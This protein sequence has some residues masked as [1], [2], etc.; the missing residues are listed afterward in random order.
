MT[1]K[2]L[3]A[4][5]LAFSIAAVSGFV[6]PPGTL[7]EA[8]TTVLAAEGPETDSSEGDF[9][10]DSRAA[11]WQG[12]EA[13]ATLLEEPGER[14][15]SS[16]FTIEVAYASEAGEPL[17]T[18]SN[19]CGTGLTWN[20]SGG[21][22]TISG[23]G[24]MNDYIES[25]AP[26]SG[27]RSQINSIVVESGVTKIGEQ[28][29]LFCDSLSSV[30]L[31]H[32]LT[33]I[34][35]AAFYGCTALEK[36]ELPSGVQEIADGLFAE[37]SALAEVSA[38]G[39]VS[40]GEYAFQNTNLK[41]FTVWKNLTVIKELA[42]FG[43]LIEA[44]DVER[45]NGVFSVVDGILFS[46]NGQ[47]LFAYPSGRTG[48]SYAIPSTVRRVC[49][50]AFM[51][52]QWLTQIVIPKGVTELGRSAFQECTALTSV[53]I[54][55]SV[56]SVDDVTFYGCTN[57]ES[58]KFGSGLKTTSYEMFEKCTALREIDFGSGLEELDARTFGY[59]NSLTEIVLPHNIKKIGNG[60]FGEC[61]Y[62][63]RF[64]SNSLT[65]IPFQAFLNDMR[66]TSV[67]LNEGI[68]DINRYAFGACWELTAVT[69]PASVNYVA[70]HA[71]EE[72]TQLTAK[73]SKL[74]PFGSNGLRMLEFFTVSGSYSYSKA[75]EVLD[76]VNQRRREAGLPD[77][78]MNAS[79]LESAMQRAAESSVLF[80]HT[81]PDGSSCMDLD[82][83]M[84]GENIAFGSV[85]PEDVMVVWMNS[86]G[87]RKNI[88]N[89]D[90][91]TIGIGCA[92]IDGRYYW[93]QCFG[94]GENTA[95]CSC[96]E[97]RSGT[98]TIQIATETFSEASTTPGVV[99]GCVEQYTYTCSLR[100]DASSIKPGGQIKAAYY[101]KNPTLNVSRAV[102][103]GEL[104]WGSSDTN[105]ASVDKGI[106]TALKGGTAQITAS[107]ANGFYK[108]SA[109]VNVKE[110]VPTPS[111]SPSPD[112]PESDPVRS[113]V[114]R[115]YTVALGRVAEETGL[116]DWTNRLLNHEVDGAGIADGFIMS[117]EFKNKNVSDQEYVDVLYR[118]FFD[119]NAD[120]GGRATWLEALENGNSRT[121]VLAGFV[122]SVEFD[123]LCGRYGIVRGV[124]ETN[125]SPIGSG[126]RQFVNRCYIKVLGREGEK[127]GVDD[128]TSRIA[129]GEQTPESV[130]KLFFSSEEYT[131][132]NT[133][134]E[135]FV[136]TLYRTFMDRASDS[137]GKADWIGRLAGGT[138]REEVLEGFSRSE[139][140]AK[141]M[142]SFGL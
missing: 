18:A 40:I 67:D 8:G 104:I 46:D 108:T 1:K 52:N 22:L 63:E 55:D 19:S 69:L 81:R 72:V 114:S 47:M 43:T 14:E 30:T 10:L 110:E 29:F 139:E 116:N 36:I 80:S 34:G 58:V 126:A 42:F 44:F 13:F 102:I 59:C 49:G 130:A 16:G 3:L 75:F 123:N 100:L 11:M 27:S 101:L 103:A 54:P 17:V 105:V 37:C 98:Q 121:F 132:K 140:F 137:A 2:K 97:D 141:I 65:V 25:A 71:F 122:N 131:N 89:G 113:F 66:L 53:V 56:T 136:E 64:T 133:S 118:T 38:P 83:L 24:E 20:L 85:S 57:L 68:T 48:T 51:K 45:G 138:S 31:P 117:E 15:L 86:E 87:H 70:S 134:N 79:L 5:M 28:A 88:L 91:T 39:A 106:I 94:I 26:W 82:D 76:I 50:G 33:S 41:S 93:A 125:E 142:Q 135:E 127:A 78:V 62:L 111:P 92:M 124:M 96:P 74:S 32:T 12:T 77:L 21:T 115:M 7:G 23:T 120:E 35:K 61:R 107:M 9:V 90:Y 60:T 4:L 95:S 129:S 73:N 84:R 6:L 112:Q 109:S 119:R 128:W 99:F